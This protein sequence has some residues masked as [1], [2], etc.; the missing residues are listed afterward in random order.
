MN[1]FPTIKDSLI[2][3][4]QPFYRILFPKGSTVSTLNGKL[5]GIIL[6]KE[7]EIG[8]I[9]AG[10]GTYVSFSLDGRVL[11]VTTGRAWIYQGISVPAGSTVYPN[12]QFKKQV[13]HA[14][15]G[16]SDIRLSEPPNAVTH[17]EDML[18]YGTAALRFDV[19]KLT[20]VYGD[21]EWNGEYFK[22]YRVGV[23]GQIERVR[24][25]DERRLH[26]P[27]GL[28]RWCPEA[29]P[30]PRDGL[31]CQPRAASQR[32]AAT[33]SFRRREAT[34]SQLGEQAGCRSRS[35]M[36]SP[37]CQPATRTGNISPERPNQHQSAT[38]PW[39]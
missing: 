23:D 6:S 8:G 36:K 9:P 25:L 18:V 30:G 20:S 35:R 14:T 17:V 37:S 4:D 12:A 31:G 32:P 1:D 39:P 27:R 19:D 16:I 15:S 13:P 5:Q 34:G 2:N 11:S 28:R 21:Y 29:G 38:S 3:Q 7:T 22:F 26:V 33:S 24:E 10:Q